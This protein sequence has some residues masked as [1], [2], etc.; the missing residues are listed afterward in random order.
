MDLGLVKQFV[1][2]VLG[3]PYGVGVAFSAASGI[4]T[5]AS[6][7]HKLSV[8]DK[9]SITQSSSDSEFLNGSQVVA[10]T[11]DSD[12]FTFAAVGV[13]DGTGTLDYYVVPV[14]KSSVK[15]ASPPKPYATVRFINK[16]S[17]GF[18]ISEVISQSPTVVD[19]QLSHSKKAE[20]EVIFYS[21]DTKG[22]FRADNLAELFEISLGFD[23]SSQFLYDN[24]LGILEI[25]PA[26][27]IDIELGDLIERRSV[28]GFTVNYIY[29]A[30][31]EDVPF[32]NSIE[33]T[34]TQL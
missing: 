7:D 30:I 27:R 20:C 2:V 1:S 22:D 24:N 17:L 23:R 15:A 13:P 26:Q 12:T 31:E 4:V 16:N 32:F 6:P 28:V 29:Q 8:D 21:N 14:I 33:A 34:V 10:S 11:P 5:V 3:K 9:F 19:H 18:S 25:T